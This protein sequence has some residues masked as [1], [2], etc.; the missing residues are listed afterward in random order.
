[1]IKLSQNDSGRAFEYGIAASFS[2]LLNAEIQD[3]KQ[4]RKAQ[5]CFELSESLEQ[6]K[7]VK[8]SDEIAMFII[9]HDN[10]G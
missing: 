6:Q 3:N 10:A 1:M 8:A 9:A 2:R 4:I 5:K 7:I